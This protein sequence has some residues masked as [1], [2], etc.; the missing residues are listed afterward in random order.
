MSQD[1]MDANKQNSDKPEQSIYQAP[2]IDVSLSRVTKKTNQVRVVHGS[3]DAYYNIE[4]KTVGM[5]RKSLRDAF[6][7]PS[8]AKAEISGKVV[9]DDFILQA[10][11]TLEFS[12]T[13]GQKGQNVITF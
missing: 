2:N 1:R 6:N 13:A 3:S 10:G 12:K 9:E 8:D 7:I 4:G 11:H 5:V